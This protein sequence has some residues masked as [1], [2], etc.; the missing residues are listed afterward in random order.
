MSTIRSSKS[1][2]IQTVYN[3]LDKALLTNKSSWGHR[4]VTAAGK[5]CRLDALIKKLKTELSEIRKNPDDFEMKKEGFASKIISLYLLNDEQESWGSKKKRRQLRKISDEL[6]GPIKHKA[7]QIKH[8]DKSKT[9]E[10]HKE[11]IGLKKHLPS[12]RD[13][14]ELNELKNQLNPNECILMHYGSHVYLITRDK[15]YR[16]DSNE[17]EGIKVIIN[18]TTREAKNYKSLEAMYQGMKLNLKQG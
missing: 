16:L 14:N 4:T 3:N 18:Q 8:K 17:K 12:F 10:A 7:I 11:F 9:K 1:D 15:H 6:F 13:L 5:T 2:D